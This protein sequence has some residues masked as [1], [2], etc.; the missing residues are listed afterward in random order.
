MTKAQIRRFIKGGMIDGLWI[1]VW[2]DP[3]Y[4]TL[5][6]LL[7]VK[8]NV[9]EAQQVYT[10][11]S[12]WELADHSGSGAVCSEVFT[13]N[14]RQ[15]LYII[16]KQ[17]STNAV[18]VHE[19]IHAVNFIFHHH[20]VKLDPDNDEHQAYYTDHLVRIVDAEYEKLAEHNKKTEQASYE[21]PRKHSRR[22]GK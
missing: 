17:G 10:L 11:T 16:L 9:M 3:I 1:K 18:K 5:I 6:W 7:I 20:G 22:K 12:G 21:K 15:N 4:S 13:E 8:D 19:I 14:G 2:D